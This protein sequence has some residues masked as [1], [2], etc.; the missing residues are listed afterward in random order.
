MSLEPPPTPNELRILHCEC[1]DFKRSKPSDYILTYD[2]GS[3]D[4]SLTLNAERDFTRDSNL[5]PTDRT[6]QPSSGTSTGEPLNLSKL[7]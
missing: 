1:E 4:P 2:H 3:H 5:P 7:T 6:K